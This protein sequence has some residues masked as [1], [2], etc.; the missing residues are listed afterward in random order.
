MKKGKEK[1]E[2]I[3]RWQRWGT[4]AN[5]DLRSLWVSHAPSSFS[6][7]GPQE[8]ERE[9]GA[10]ITAIC[11]RAS[12]SK[13]RDLRTRQLTPDHVPNAGRGGRGG[14]LGA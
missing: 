11:H 6:S 14:D 7:F 2:E 9:T 5:F 10:Y 13:D 4:R 1:K 3:Q 8:G 12:G